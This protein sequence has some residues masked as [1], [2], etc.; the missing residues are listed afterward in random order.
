[1]RPGALG[2]KVCF[3]RVGIG[4]HRGSSRTPLRETT[5]GSRHCSEAS[6]VSQGPARPVRLDPRSLTLDLG[7]ACEGRIPTPPANSLSSPQVKTPWTSPQYCPPVQLCLPIPEAAKTPAPTPKS[8][9]CGLRSPRARTAAATT[10]RISRVRRPGTVKGPAGP[11]G[12]GRGRRPP[13]PR[14]C[15]PGAR[16]APA[17]ASAGGA[18]L[19][20]IAAHLPA[21]AARPAPTPAARLALHGARGLARG[22]G[23]LIQLAASPPA[24]AARQWLLAYP[25]PASA[26]PSSAAALLSA[27]PGTRQ[28]GFSALGWCLPS[29][30]RSRGRR[31]GQRLGA[32]PAVGPVFVPPGGEER[33]D[34]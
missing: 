26:R 5:E 2:P 31:A 8:P 34:G 33:M 28:T 21:V 13:T 18:P 1:M 15:L 20:A 4:S 7:V 32:G 19:R 22:P 17:G 10:S 16:W 14:P 23:K 6:G 9:P 30:S 24:L 11:M 3:R 12:C 25:R 27:M 29:P